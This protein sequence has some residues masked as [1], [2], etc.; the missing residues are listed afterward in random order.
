MDKTP[1]RLTVEQGFALANNTNATVYEVFSQFPDRSR[2][3]GNA[4]RAFT[5]GTG[6]ELSHV[7]D[8][9]PWGDLPK[10]GV[11]VD[12]SIPS[13]IEAS[14]ELRSVHT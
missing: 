9:F 8:N 6:Y 5:E 12:V 14:G 11:V 1:T 10:D 2:R 4:M 3:F 7:V 13:P